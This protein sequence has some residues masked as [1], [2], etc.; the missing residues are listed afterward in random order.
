[1][2]KE[3]IVVFDFGGQYGHLISRR[4]RDL[5]YFAL[6]VPAESLEEKDAVKL[7]ESYKAVV[8]SGGPASVWEK[9]HDSIVSA[10]LSKERPLLGICYGHQLLAKV[11]GGKVGPSP[12]P[13]FGPTIVN[14]V[15]D[16]PIFE[17]MPR[18]LRVWMSHNDAVLT[19]PPDSSVL[20]TSKGSPVAAFRYRDAPVY[21]VQWHPEVHHTM[22]G[23]ELF[24]NWARVAG[25]EKSWREQDIVSHVRDT[26]L[27]DLS[28][29]EDPECNIVAA[30]SGGVDSTVA[31][32]AVKHEAG[33]AVVPV[34]IDHGF[35][36]AGEL[37][38]A[39]KLLRES[40][41]DPY[42]IDAK[43]RFLKQ[44]KGVE[45]PEEK[46]TIISKVYWDV[47]RESLT[48]F[49]ACGLV[50]GTIYPDLIESGFLPGSSKIKSHHNVVLRHSLPQN[51]VLIEPL[52]WLYKDEVRRLAIHYGLPLDFATKQP[53]PG[54]GLAVRIEGEVTEEKLRIVRLADKIVREVIEKHWLHS[55]LWQ[56]FAVLTRSKATGVKGDRRAFGYVVAVRI[57]ESVEAMTAHFAHL[58][59]NVLEE[60][61]NRIT[62]EIS[63]VTRVVYDITSKPPAT[64]EWE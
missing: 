39:A 27:E 47:L 48:E 37:E 29:I 2:R 56:Y 24:E 59:W 62:G 23:T 9:S 34:L 49:K 13:E 21:G 50:Q 17:G 44:I 58:P 22:Y 32:I 4:L 38:N 26:V 60:I 64:I 30:V 46:R 8:L 10:A 52:R 11:L 20:A 45:D 36:P 40:G 35:H 51:I 31:A 55:R 41:L 28:Q 63:E 57:V 7:I 33:K 53:V 25:L 1:M 18:R 19:P 6:H 14:I 15:K 12:R 5:G 3:G 16:D 54:P 61:S 42:I 43:E